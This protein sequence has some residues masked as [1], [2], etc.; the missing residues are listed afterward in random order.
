MVTW[1]T[2]KGQ[3][4]K[5]NNENLNSKTVQIQN[6]H[7][8]RGNVNGLMLDIKEKTVSDPNNSIYDSQAWSGP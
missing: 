3:K 4:N 7:M 2:W 1:D 8:I 6:R 5:E